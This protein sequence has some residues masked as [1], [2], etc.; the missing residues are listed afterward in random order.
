MS[1]AP[2]AALWMTG[3]IASFSA[4]AV[5][6]RALGTVH[7]TF[8]IMTYRSIVGLVVVCALLTASGSWAQVST[9][10]L[11]LH[12]LRNTVHFAGQNLW[13]FA[14][15]AIPLAQVFALEFPQ[16]LWV[17]LLSP[18]LLGER[19]TR[20]RLIAAL[21]GFAGT[22][23]VAR[24]GAA[25][26]GPGVAAAAASAVFFA[27]TTIA[28]KNLTRISGIGGIMFWL[29]AMQF[30]LGLLCA[31]W[32]GDIALPGTATIPWLVLVG[33]AGLLAH[34]CIARAL[35]IAPA[36]VVIPM[37]FARLPT[38]A[39]IGMIL[40]GEALELPVLAGAALILAGN[41]LN[42]LAETRPARL[43]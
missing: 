28:T 5:A 6:G 31:G 18:L 34:F 36:T 17:I 27:L 8:E 11:W 23:L 15:T 42:I 40:Y 25:A 13:F 32:D 4:M 43:A 1:P 10:R 16:P 35:A 30:A 20:A 9:R 38:I 41:Y 29:T 26:F 12:G 19:L 22:L 37:D 14:V 2:R 21:I 7:D 24:P 33:L 3:A 39:L